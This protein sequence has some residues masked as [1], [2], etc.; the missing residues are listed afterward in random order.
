MYKAAVLDAY[1]R[2]KPSLTV[3]SIYHSQKSWSEGFADSSAHGNSPM[4]DNAQAK[5]QCESSYATCRCTAK[6]Q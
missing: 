4:Y 5:D 6:G 2:H 3:Y 1:T